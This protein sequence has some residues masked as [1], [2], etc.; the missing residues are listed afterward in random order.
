MKIKSFLANVFSSMGDILSI[1]PRDRREVYTVP[2]KLPA[3]G[4]GRHFDAVWAVIGRQFE[5]EE[6]AIQTA[7]SAQDQLTVHNGSGKKDTR[8]SGTEETENGC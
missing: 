5:K 2:D 8:K 6:T 4:T 7:G 3:R 1:A